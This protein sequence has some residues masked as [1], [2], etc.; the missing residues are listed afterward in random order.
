VDLVA[1]YIESLLAARD[2]P[3][4]DAGITRALLTQHGYIENA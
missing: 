2:L 4:A 1:R 3:D